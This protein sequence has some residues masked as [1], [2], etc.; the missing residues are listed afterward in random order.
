MKRYIILTFLT[1]SITCSLGIG[2]CNLMELLQVDSNNINCLVEEFVDRNDKD[3]FDSLSILIPVCE[4]LCYFD[5]G[6]TSNGLENLK[7]FCERHNFNYLQTIFEKE[8]NNYNVLFGKNW[9]RQIKKLDSIAIFCCELGYAKANEI[10]NYSFS[11]F[12]ANEIKKYF[13]STSYTDTY[14]QNNLKRKWN[15]R[16]LKSVQLEA[17]GNPIKLIEFHWQQLMRDTVERENFKFDGFD[18]LLELIKNDYTKQ[19]YN[20]LLRSFL[21]KAYLT[22]TSDKN[23]F[24]G[25][26]LNSSEQIFYNPELSKRLAIKKIFCDTLAYYS[27]R[28]G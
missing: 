27:H 6:K 10:Q 20:E 13:K 15:K 3:K 7:S 22:S 1:T 17:R 21:N 11:K 25:I 9:P 5:Q 23:A 16:H 26:E 2:Q 14:K 8:S 18:Y 12:F 4:A 28:P 19:S 24:L